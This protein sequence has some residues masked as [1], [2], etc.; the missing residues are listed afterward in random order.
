MVGQPLAVV[1]CGSGSSRMSIYSR[2]SDNLVHEDRYVPSNNLP[3]LAPALAAGEHESWIAKLKEILKDE[4]PNIR[5]VVGTTGGL[6]KAL[7]QGKLQQ[8]HIDTFVERLA[9]AFPG[10]AQLM[11]FTGEQEAAMELKAVR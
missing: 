11:Q 9:S 7:A 10:Q 3:T 2:H 4:D 6:R 8:V 5:V 1:D